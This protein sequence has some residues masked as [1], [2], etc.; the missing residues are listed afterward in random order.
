MIDHFSLQLGNVLVARL[1]PF[2]Y[3]VQVCEITVEGFKC[4]D[5]G[6]NTIY[7]SGQ[8][9]IEKVELS[10]EVIY[11]L[12][13]TKMQNGVYEKFDIEMSDHAIAQVLIQLH[14]E[15]G[16]FSLLQVVI[17][18]SDGFHVEMKFQGDIAALHELQNAYFAI[19]KFPLDITGLNNLGQ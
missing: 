19:T 14:G 16:F 6:D 2:E 3:F 12:G 13:F 5:T 7:D 11:A 4:I 18:G 9:T 17:K 10:D 8:N 15:Y 1:D